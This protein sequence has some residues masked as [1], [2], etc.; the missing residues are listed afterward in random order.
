M[1]NLLENVIRT[2]LFEG[3]AVAIIKSLSS[4]EI[5]AAKAGGAAW[6]YGVLLKGD[7]TGQ[8]R[9]LS[10]VTGVTIANTEV[11]NTEK[12]QIAIGSTSKF[13]KGDY[14]YV[15]KN[16]ITDIPTDTDKKITGDT[17]KEK[18]RRRFLRVLIMPGNIMALQV[19]DEPINTNTNNKGIPEKGKQEREVG[20]KVAAITYIGKSPIMFEDNYLT[21]LNDAKKANPDAVKG[22]NTSTIDNVPTNIE[23]VKDALQQVKTAADDLNANPELKLI[24]P[25]DPATGKINPDA[26]KNGVYEWYVIDYSTKR[27]QN[28]VYNLDDSDPNVYY[29]AEGNKVINTPGHWA[30]YTKENFFTNYSDASK[31]GYPGWA[32]PNTEDKLTAKFRQPETATSTP[33]AP[34]TEQIK[35]AKDY[36]AWANSTPE[37]SAKYGK[38]ST[39]DLDAVSSKPYNTNFEKSYAVGKDEFER[40]TPG[41]ITPTTEKKKG[42]IVTLKPGEFNL[43]YKKSDGTFAYAKTTTAGNDLSKNKVKIGDISGNYYYVMIGTKGYWVNKNYFK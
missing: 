43:H 38:T 2:F 25:G 1:K 18:D 23:A 37:L 26:W 14:T 11:D 12:N 22:F 35:L 8:E 6:A 5:A 9:I 29:W 13:A 32:D 31:L 20:V 19:K 36:R 34:T 7:I 39:Y 21:R 30:S 40:R 27:F 42:D 15:V 33:T 16:V 17:F 10:Q 3:R 4:K 41:T 24:A 28:K